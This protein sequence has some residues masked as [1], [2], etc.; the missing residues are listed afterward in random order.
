MGQKWGVFNEDGLPTAFYDADLHAVEAIPEA[1]VEISDADWQSYLSGQYY[2]DA[3]GQC[4]ART[5]VVD[6]PSEIANRQ[7]V[8]NRELGAYIYGVYDAGT[9]ASMQAL[10][11]QA[12][13]PAA[14][15]TDIESVWAWIASIMTYYYQCKSEIAAL[16]D[17]DAVAAYTWD[18]SRF[19]ATLPAVTLQGIFAAI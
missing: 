7:A 18:F 16:T 15:K 19:D 17:A 9:Q 12:A 5:I 3:E 8:L 11:S 2:R 13:T 14:V 10:W 1:A 6:L 4:V